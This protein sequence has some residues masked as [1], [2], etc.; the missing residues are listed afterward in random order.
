VK[1]FERER[2]RER[3]R[4]F[5]VFVEQD[6]SSNLWTTS[7]VKCISGLLQQTCLSFF[8]LFTSICRL[9]VWGLKGYVLIVKTEPRWFWSSA[10]VVIFVSKRHIPKNILWV[11]LCF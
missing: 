10:S 4:G 9:T 2:E 1:S 5:H 3:E 8:S 6:Q 7:R 11:Q